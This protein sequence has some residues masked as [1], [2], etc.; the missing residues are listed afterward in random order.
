MFQYLRSLFS[1]TKSDSLGA[2]KSF[3]DAYEWILTYR[4]AKEYHTAVL[5]ARELLLKIKSGITYY[6][7][8]EKKISILWSSNLESV[9]KIAK[10]KRKVIEKNLSTFYHWEQKIHKLILDCERLESEAKS[11]KEKLQIEAEIT[12][13]IKVIQDLITKKE[14]ANALHH[15]KKL[16]SAHYH[17]KRTTETL[18]KTQKQYDKHV[19]NEKKEDVSEKKIARFLQESWITPPPTLVQEEKEKKLLRFSFFRRFHELYDDFK[20]KQ[21]EKKEY[22][23]NHRT[24]QMLE[25]VLIETGSITRVTEKSSEENITAIMES[26]LTKNIS[27]FSIDGFRFHGE[28][29]GKDKIVGDTFGSYRDGTK[30]IFYFWDAT[31]HGVQAWFTV[32]MLTKIFF[33]Y[34][35]KKLSFI[36]LYFTLNNEL[37]KL[38]KWHVFVTGVL[39]EHDG[40]SGR[41]QFLWAGHDPMYIFRH[42]TKTVEK[43]IPGWLALWVR[44]ITNKE[45]LKP[46]EIFLKEHDVLIGYTDGI[47]EARNSQG[48]LYGMNRLEKALRLHAPFC[49]NHPDK[50]YEKI[51]SDVAEFQGNQVFLDDVSLFIF[52]RDPNKDLITNKDELDQLLRELDTSS[53]TIELDYKGKTREELLEEMEKKRYEKELKARMTILEQYYKLGEYGKL[54]QEIANCYKQ[55]FVHE[56]MQFFLKKIIKNEDKWKT[57]KLE[58][59]LQKKYQMLRDLYDK[60]DYA[61][62]IREAVD[63]LY[64]NGNI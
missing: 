64:K 24:L 49:K 2:V 35:K 60:G 26:G 27:N 42:E 9:A 55:G 56:R 53:R 13:E 10:E 17:S 46:K 7:E 43:L 61:I 33:E 15:A 59:R 32:S 38:L 62:V 36:D 22:I 25:K 1:H 45:S 8:A 12:A 58:D 19:K 51:L 44:I 30:S 57:L 5:A 6:S 4:K 28:I 47:I 37:K 41:L 23:R 40:G 54:K 48:E 34:S 21:Q 39:F 29:L 31:G 52:E 18:L 63:V 16:A 3:Q 14:F 11:E 50:L 20:K